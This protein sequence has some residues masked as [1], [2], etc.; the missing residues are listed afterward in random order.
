MTAP[1][2]SR[3]RN[4]GSRKVPR[5]SRGASTGRT[6]Q[7]SARLRNDRRASARS[8]PG[9]SAATKPRATR[10]ATTPSRR[11][12]VAEKA[13]ARRAQRSAMLLD[14]GHGAVASHV[15]PLTT[16]QGVRSL[17]RLCVP[18]SRGAFVLVVMGL[19][20]AGLAFTLWLSTQAIA[21]SYQ[22]ESLRE[23][24]AALAERVEQLQREVTRQESPASLAERARELGMV[25]SGDPARI[26][27]EPDGEV[28]LFGD[29][30][31]VDSSGGESDEQIE[32]A[33]VQ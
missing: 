26:V 5:G 11:G 30:E 10:T 17:L 23:E 12:S 21:G 16:G 8:T 14:G 29:P 20:A 32:H 19:L 15:S 28:S 1:A 27:V 33:E 24:N 6:A 13:Y 18:R 2:R 4:G 7:R 9:R 3:T 31:S 25:P 22:L